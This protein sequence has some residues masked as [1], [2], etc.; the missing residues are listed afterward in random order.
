MR[1]I[2]SKA[3]LRLGLAGGGTDVSPYSDIYGGAILNA[4]IHLFAHAVI[5]ETD[6]KKIVF[7]RGNDG[8]QEV[9]P[10]EKHL[11]FDPA[12]DLAIGTYNRLMKDFSP[13]PRG[14]ELI[15]YMDV[16]HGSGLG[17]SSTLAVA[18]LG[19]MARLFHIPLGKYDLAHLAYEIERLDLGMDGGKQDQYAAT[20][21][22]FNF[23]EFYA[24]DKVI[25]NPLGLSPE[26]VLELEE[27]LLLFYT[28]TKRNSSEII[29]EQIANVQTGCDESIQA[30]HALKLQARQM[31]EALLNEEAH[32]LGSIL[33]EG[34]MNKKKMAGNISN[35]FL[36]ELYSLA[37]EKGAL[38]GKISG[39][40]G[41]GYMFFYVPSE[42]KMDVARTLTAK[43]GK[44]QPFSFCQNGLWVW[45]SKN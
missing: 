14:F 27:N 32:R 43:G 26:F 2:K 31:K 4:T 10:L 19:A 40:G 21:G 18:I 9:F 5:R 20:F 22:G 15:Y 7:K 35:D 38:G 29:R 1:I 39:A 37:L 44:M 16:A 41:G 36:D 13:G 12:F 34:W 24:N 23:M 42:N 45:E 25:V 28:D 3:P 6:E 30:M 33:H 11:P 8:L 17:T